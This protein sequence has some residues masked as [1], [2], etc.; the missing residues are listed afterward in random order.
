MNWRY[1]LVSL[2]GLVM[3]GLGYLGARWIS[4]PP[5]GSLEPGSQI[6]LDA[7]D[8]VSGC[9]AVVAKHELMVRFSGPASALTPFEVRL[10]G[11]G[12]THAEVAFVM[13]GMD[14]GLNRYQLLPV[15]T[16]RHV[17]RVVL[18]VCSSGR[19]DWVADFLVTVDGK[20]YRLILPFNVV[21]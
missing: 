11:G 3:L 18:P 21:H 20:T 14:M 5:G 9:R 2:I 13:P 6:R 12:V 7:C 19:H 1:V 4:T 17:A 16:T 15:S 8:P 10:D